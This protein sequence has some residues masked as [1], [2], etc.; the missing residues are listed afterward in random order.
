ML[1]CHCVVAE[2][3]TT[4]RPK[5]THTHTDTLLNWEGILGFSSSKYA[6][7]ATE[8]VAVYKIQ[9]AANHLALGTLCPEAFICA[10]L[11]AQLVKNPPA[12]QE[13]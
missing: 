11:V 2:S 5:H 4:E 13:T 8:S 7:V 1:I 10:S 9:F 3:D 6:H 12:K